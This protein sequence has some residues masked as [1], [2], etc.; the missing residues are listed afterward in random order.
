MEANKILTVGFLETAFLMKRGFIPK[1]M[2]GL[3]SVFDNSEQLR[4]E[5]NK[6]AEYTNSTRTFEEKADAKLFIYHF[7]GYKFSNGKRLFFE[8]DTYNI[9]VIV[10]D[11]LAIVFKK[12]YD[13]EGFY[14]DT[15]LTDLNKYDREMAE[16][17]SNH[18]NNI[19]YGED[20]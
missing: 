19:R 13:Q 8:N 10:R 5:L 18:Y 9:R 20:Y 11:E 4:N 6:F 14:L 3:K 1:S 17:L 12:S 2:N 16:E 7:N 15:I